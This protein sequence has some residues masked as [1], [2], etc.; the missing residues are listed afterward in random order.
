M[1]SNDCCREAENLLL[2][3]AHRYNYKTNKCRG[4]WFFL[5]TLLRQVSI[6]VICGCNE[7]NKVAN[8]IPAKKGSVI[9]RGFKYKSTF[10]IIS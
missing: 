2:I 9:E 4:M 8:E 3:F 10:L 7:F 6:C 1:G 5:G